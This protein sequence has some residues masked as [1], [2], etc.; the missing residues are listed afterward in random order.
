MVEDEPCRLPVETPMDLQKAID[1]IPAGCR[2][3]LTAEDI[4]N[5]TGQ[6]IEQFVADH[7]RIRQQQTR[8]SLEHD[9]A[10]ERLYF[11]KAPSN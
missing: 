8:L 11:V 1:A 4:K 9:E 10:S 6:T 2:A 5:L 7:R 3:Y